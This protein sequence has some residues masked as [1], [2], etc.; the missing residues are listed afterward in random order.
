MGDSDVGKSS[1]LNNLWNLSLKIGL[2][3]CTEKVEKISEDA[4]SEIYDSPGSTDETQ[5]N[6]I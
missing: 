6:Y 3:G 1:L 2:G 4:D 5:Y